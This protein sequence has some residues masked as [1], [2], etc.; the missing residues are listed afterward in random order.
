MSRAYS[1]DC[2]RDRVGGADR[3]SGESSGEEGD[4]ASSFGTESADGF[5]LGDAGSHG[6][7]DA[8]PAEVGAESDGGVGGEDDRPMI[9]PPSAFEFLG[10]NDVGAKQGA[11]DNAHRLLS[12]VAAVAEAVGGG[13]EELQF[14]EP[15]VD[16]SRRLVA[17]DPKDGRHKNEGEDEAHDGCNHDKDQ[18]LVPTGSD[19][20]LE[21]AGANNSGSSHAPDEGV[22]GGSGQTPPPG[23][24]IP[25][26]GAEQACDHHVLSD[27]FDVDHATADGF[28]DGGPEQERGNEIKERGPDYGYFRGKDAGGDDGGNAVGG[29]VKS[30]EKVE[31]ESD[32]NGDDEEQ[33][34]R[35]HV[36][37]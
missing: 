37:L 23:E 6:V 7:D 11:G 28:G 17:E 36:G 1:H 5:E 29:V 34:V 35:F 3:N 21:G 30:I 10:S 9:V 31:G 8:P 27:G 14:A 13:R 33:E 12:V 26:N 25:N 20:D 32:Q 22:R 2:S 24:E 15:G 4:G 19:D 16:A 18:S